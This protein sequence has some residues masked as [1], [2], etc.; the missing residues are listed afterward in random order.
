MKLLFHNNEQL[1]PIRALPPWAQLY[2]Q[3]TWAAIR[4][5]PILG[6]YLYLVVPALRV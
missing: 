3:R 2:R 1:V 4:K 6:L 5:G